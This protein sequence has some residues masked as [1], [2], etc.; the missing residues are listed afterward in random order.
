MYKFVD[1]KGITRHK[2]IQ[3]L[4]GF[5]YETNSFIFNELG[6][7]N[8]VNTVLVRV[9]T[10]GSLNDIDTAVDT[11]VTDSIQHYLEK[12]KKSMLLEIVSV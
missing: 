9:G 7:D 1:V 6:L 12:K 11:L 10:Y 2:I 3:K 8:M 4:K 5:G